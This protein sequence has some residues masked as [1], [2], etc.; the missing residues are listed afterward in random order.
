MPPLPV[1]SIVPV[2]PTVTSATHATPSLS[3]AMHT[4]SLTGGF[5]YATDLQTGAVTIVPVSATVPVSK[6]ALPPVSFTDASPAM[7]KDVYRLS[8]SGLLKPSSKSQV[9]LMPSCYVTAGWHGVGCDMV[10]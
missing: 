7:D 10:Q 4:K 3:S 8:Q 5:R 1:V 9:A 2:R 6:V